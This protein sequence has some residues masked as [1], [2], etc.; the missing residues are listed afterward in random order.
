MVQARRGGWLNMHVPVDVCVLAGVSAA[1]IDFNQ[2]DTFQHSSVV[3]PTSPLLAASV[4]M[5][6]LCPTLRISSETHSRHMVEQDGTDFPPA[7]HGQQLSC[8]DMN[9]LHAERSI[10]RRGGESRVWQPPIGRM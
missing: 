10:G 6:M 4:H 3:F 7:D 2:S 5:L 8:A 9:L 1:A